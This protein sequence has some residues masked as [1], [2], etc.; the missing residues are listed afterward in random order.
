M[1]KDYFENHINLTP[2][3]IHEV[4]N[5]LQMEDMRLKVQFLE[6]NK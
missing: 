2:Q 4:W 6:P 3:Q 1:K 5:D